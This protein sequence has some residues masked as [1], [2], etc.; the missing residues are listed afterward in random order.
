MQ[1]KMPSSLNSGYYNKVS[2]K[3]DRKWASRNAGRTHMHTNGFF[4]VK[5][6]K[7][8]E[9]ECP[10]NEA[11]QTYGIKNVDRL[12][13]CRVC[14]KTQ[15]ISSKMTMENIMEMARMENSLY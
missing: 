8:V 12:Y 4:N 7:M 2:I 15:K 13:S 6:R 9:N 5:N 11:G 3:F 1:M 10:F 14:Q